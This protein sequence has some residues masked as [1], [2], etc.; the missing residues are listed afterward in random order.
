MKPEK[1]ITILLKPGAYISDNASNNA[2]LIKVSALYIPGILIFF[3]VWP[4]KYPKID[5]QT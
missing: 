4:E 2:L 5:S 3:L 1:N